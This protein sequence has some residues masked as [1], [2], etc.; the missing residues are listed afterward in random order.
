[1]NT[2]ETNVKNKKLGVKTIIIIIAAAI[3][4]AGT[5]FVIYKSVK[6]F[7]SGNETSEVQAHENNV[8]VFKCHMFT[9]LTDA[10]IEKIKKV[11]TDAVGDKV[12]DIRKGDI[13]LAKTQFITGENGEVINVGDIVYITFSLL[14]N[15][16]LS[17]AVTA[18]IDTYKLNEKEPGMD[19]N[20]IME[21]VNGY[22]SEYDKK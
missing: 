6:K 21:I 16:E 20:D 19:I 10:D 9:V 2:N 13:P 22:R 7:I 15:A 8:T 5:G 4:L 18:V 14:D 3:V 1:M 12:L 11:V 17:K